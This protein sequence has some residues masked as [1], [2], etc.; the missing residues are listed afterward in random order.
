M[1][2]YALLTVLSLLACAVGLGQEPESY[3]REFQRALRRGA[4][5]KVTVKVADESG[6][7][8]TNAN[9]KVYF[10]MSSG[11]SDGKREKRGRSL[12]LEKQQKGEDK[13]R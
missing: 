8:V 13:E 7:P 6:Q 3:S 1:K 10:R 11:K 5:A 12:T 2:K 9:M 4:K